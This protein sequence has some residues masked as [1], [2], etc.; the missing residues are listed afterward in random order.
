LDPET[1][2][3]VRSPMM[4][5]SL[6]YVLRT[7]FVVTFEMASARCAN[8]GHRAQSSVPTAGKFTEA[9]ET[10][11][12]PLSVAA[13]PKHGARHARTT[14]T[15]LFIDSP[16][17][18]RCFSD[19]TQAN[20]SPGLAPNRR[21]QATTSTALPPRGTKLAAGCERQHRAHGGEVSEQQSEEDNDGRSR[22]RRQQDRML[23]REARR[24]PWLTRLLRHRWLAKG[25]P[26]PGGARDES[27]SER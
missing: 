7:P 5:G 19:A 18:V 10:T 12:D 27:G 24:E 8:P 22:E 26:N 21:R 23:E 3:P 2:M 6:L 20:G 14:A 1:F 11:F 17:E 13:K 16:Q 25:R 4:R 15:V 9:A